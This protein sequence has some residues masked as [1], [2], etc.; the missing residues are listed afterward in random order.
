MKYK[1]IIYSDISAEI[2]LSIFDPTTGISEYHAII[3]LTDSV[4]DAF[5]QYRQ[6]NEAIRLLE[7]ELRVKSIWQRYFVSDAVNQAFYLKQTKQNAAV[8]V[9]QQPLLN[10]TKV[11]VWVYLLPDVQLEKDTNGVSVMQH[12]GYQHLYH[13]Q[14]HA[15]AED[16]RMQTTDIFRQYVEQLSA[17]T[18]TLADHCIRTWVYVQGV[19]THYE[20]MVVAR[21]MCFEEEGLTPQTHFIASTGIEGKYRHPEVLVFMDAYAVRGL[22]PEQIRYLYAPTHLNPTHE[23]GVTF[24]R[25]TVVQYGDRRHVF[26]SGTASINNRG[27]IEHSMD[28]VGQTER[29]FE[30]IR[31]LLYE[32]ECKM[33]DVAHLIVYLRDTA[34]YRIVVAYL[35]RIS[36]DTPVIVLWAPVCRPGW[37]IEAECMAVKPGKDERYKPY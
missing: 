11:G 5:Q 14:L 20:G 33:E 7:E 3:Q 35:K 26:I 9:V 22:Q 37:L 17:Y 2:S 10:G 25:G 32:A 24:E 1:K 27:E 18:C 12:S 4:A 30:N 34:D 23:Y 28:I 31:A 19:D 15:L 8:S 16:E 36:P 13:T 29:V 21:R 6:I